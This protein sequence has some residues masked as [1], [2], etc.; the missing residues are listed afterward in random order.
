M[1]VLLFTPALGAK[2]RSMSGHSANTSIE[3]DGPSSN[4]HC[5]GIIYGLLP[6]IR[7]CLKN[8]ELNAFLILCQG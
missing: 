3:A 6:A 5:E 7:F 8:R 4:N 1:D 2:L